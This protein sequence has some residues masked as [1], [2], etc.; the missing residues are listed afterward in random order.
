MRCHAYQGKIS[1][2]T[3]EGLNLDV[4]VRC[5]LD[6]HE[7]VLRALHESKDRLFQFKILNNSDLAIC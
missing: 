4:Q 5:K 2:L 3:E 6:D 7:A 1:T